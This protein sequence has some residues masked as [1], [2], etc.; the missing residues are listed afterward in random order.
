[1]TRTQVDIKSLIRT[2]PDFPKPGVQFRD[3]TTLLKDRDGFHDVIERLANAYANQALDK[4]AGIESRGFIIAAALA[5]RLNVG[6]VPIRKRGKLPAENFGCDYALEY[7]S[8]RLEM[9][10]DAIARD[11]RVLLVDDLIATGG[12]AEAAARLIRMAGGSV[13]GCA[14]VIDLPGLGGR[15]RLESLGYPVLS[16]CDFS[17]H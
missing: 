13:A 11:E 7:G 16:L 10:R 12:T 2:I 6:F 17:G 9:H 1:M 5:Y 15:R 3:I 8:D 4:I 14:V